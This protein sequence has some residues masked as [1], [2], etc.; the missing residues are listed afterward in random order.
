MVDTTFTVDVI[1]KQIAELQTILA[2]LLDL[3][4]KMDPEKDNDP[5]PEIALCRTCNVN[6]DHL[7]NICQCCGSNLMGLEQ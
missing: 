2:E 6:T 7:D 3:L 4:E 5:I 1:R